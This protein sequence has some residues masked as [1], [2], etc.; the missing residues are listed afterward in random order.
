MKAVK[1]RVIICLIIIAVAFLVAVFPSLN[2]SVYAYQKELTVIAG[3]KTYKFSGEEIGYYGG[4]YYLKCA[5]GVVDKIYYDTL[6]KPIDAKIDFIPTLANPFII[7]NEQYGL[8]INKNKLLEN[9]SQALNGNDFTVK[10]SFISLKPEITKKQ[11]KEQTFLRATF[12]TEYPNS[13]PNRKHNIKLAA[14]LINGTVLKDGCE[15]SFNKTVGQ[16][17]EENGFKNAVVIENGEFI[18]GL[19][20]GVCQVSTTLYNAALLSGLTTTERHAHSLLSSYIEPSFDAMVNEGFSDLKFKN[21]T[22]DTIYIAAFASDVAI[23]FKIY[24][25]KL[26]SS[27]ERLSITTT[28]LDPEDDEIIEDDELYMGEREVVRQSK[29]GLKSDGYLIEYLNGE[30]IRT[31][32]L[33]SDSYKPIRAQVKVGSKPKEYNGA[34]LNE[35]YS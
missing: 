33:H 31:L 18:D 32:K 24:G 23:T 17:T 15:F 30:R 13:A 20:G 11:L 29:Q 2:A 22:G 12:K 28:T 5:L 19:G 9:I 1:N 35:A 4:R 26:L 7:T 25:K 3:D 6:K 8:A 10:A 21:Q 27:Y 34:K 16:R 14:S